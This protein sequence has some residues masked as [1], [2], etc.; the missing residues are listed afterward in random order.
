MLWCLNLDQP[1][2]SII[3]NGAFDEG[4]DDQA[5]WVFAAMSG[6]EYRSPDPPGPALN[7]MQIWTDHMSRWDM[8]SCGGGLKW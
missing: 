8:T 3:Q 6:A 7:W 4:N 2:I 5:F 1:T